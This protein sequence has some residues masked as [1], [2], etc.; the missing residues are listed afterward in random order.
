MIDGRIFFV[1]EEVVQI[2]D[3]KTSSEGALNYLDA[4]LMHSDVIVQA[5]RIFN[6]GTL[7]CAN[8]QPISMNIPNQ[9]SILSLHLCEVDCTDKVVGEARFVLS[10]IQIFESSQ[11]RTLYLD[12]TASHGCLEGATLQ[13]RV[14]YVTME[15]LSSHLYDDYLNFAQYFTTGDLANTKSLCTASLGMAPFVPIPLSEMFQDQEDL[16]R[17][18]D[19]VVTSSLSSNDKQSDYG[20][21]DDTLMQ[22]TLSHVIITQ[23]QSW[24][25]TTFRPIFE[26][27]VKD[28]AVYIVSNLN[29]R[30]DSSGNAKRLKDIF[31]GILSAIR[32]KLHELP[33]AVKNE[34]H[35][36][37]QLMSTMTG[38]D[39]PGS[40]SLL[41]SY[42]LLCP[43]FRQPVESGLL[44][45]GSV[46]KPGLHRI[47]KTLA[48]SSVSLCRYDEFAP[49]SQPHF[50]SQ[51][52]NQAHDEYWAIIEAILSKQTTT[53]TPVLQKRVYAD[54]KDVSF[55]DA[56]ACA[57]RCLHQIIVSPE[58]SSVFSRQIDLSITPD[59]QDIKVLLK[60]L[61][62]PR[63][64]VN[65]E[66]L[67]KTS[68][69]FKNRNSF[70]RKKSG[71]SDK[72]S[73]ELFNIIDSIS[74]S[75]HSP[76]GSSSKDSSIPSFSVRRDSNIQQVDG[77]LAQLLTTLESGARDGE[78]DEDDHAERERKGSVI[79]T[80]KID[81]ESELDSLLQ[82][83]SNPLRPS[84]STSTLSKS[85]GNS[86]AAPQQPS[87]S[88]SHRT[89]QPLLSGPAIPTPISSATA[90]EKPGKSDLSR[91]VT[92]A[93]PSKD[94]SFKSSIRTWSS[95]TNLFRFSQAKKG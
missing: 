71:L 39:L 95:D 77:E 53:A 90:H 16:V 8:W 82:D 38:L 72:A 12:C 41:V 68:S 18:F 76:D 23:I 3:E 35:R 32:A 54:P 13:L 11:L 57:S 34:L 88:Y 49:P 5:N 92:G 21:A 46:V 81:L 27:V 79:Y 6:H 91:R 89:D 4:H 47:L 26:R 14:L 36:S 65:L 62:A 31:C 29:A 45:P 75:G 69:S 58:F 50:F 74:D 37:S 42:F 86:D 19:C 61:P 80:G 44:A 10:W 22:R 43:V 93:E 59:C 33:M 67:S 70:R 64:A 84:D 56:I 78:W 48:Q 28:T 51:L 9:D 17:L 83:L 25:A 2:R 52:C 85:V 94:R 1:V 66:S 55:L 63:G 30:F 15:P 20:L 60:V 24:V 73:S 87:T 7:L 40:C